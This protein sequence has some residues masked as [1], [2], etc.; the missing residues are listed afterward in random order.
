MVAGVDAR[1]PLKGLGCQRLTVDATAGGV[2]LTVPLGAT[3]ALFR[4]ITAHLAFTDDGVTAPTTT[5]GMELYT[6]DLIWYNGNLNAFRAIRT[7]GSS[8]TLIVNYYTVA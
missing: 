8:A 7:T 5:V 1:T 6:D 2:A 4:V 3:L